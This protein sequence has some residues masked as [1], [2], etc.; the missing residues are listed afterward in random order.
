[1]MKKHLLMKTLLVA[2]VCL[3]GGTSSVWGASNFLTTWTGQVGTATN[4]G[5]FEY[6][7]KKVKIAAGETYVYTLTNFNDGNNEHYWQNWVVEGNLGDKYFDCEA[8]GH[9]WQAGSGPVPSYSQVMA[10]TDVEN[11]QTAYNGAN[12]TITIS[13]NAAGDQFTVT[14]TSN[15]LG[16]T[17]GNTDKYYGGTWTVAVGA[18]EEWD[19]YITEEYAHF[20][21]TKVVKN[22]SQFN[23]VS[24]ESAYTDQDNN[25]TN[26]DGTSVDNLKLYYTQYRDW[27]NNDGTVKVNTSGKMSFYKF[28]LTDIKNKLT[29]DGGTITGVTFSVYGN[30]DGGDCGKVRILGYNPVWSSSTITNA[31]VTN[32]AG[33]IPGT[34]SGTGSFQPLNTTSEMTMS[35]AGTTLTANALAYVNSAIAAG[36]DY[37]T[38]AMAANYTRTGL[39]KTWANLEFTYTAAVVYE[40]TFVETNSL[41]PTVTVYTDAERT[42]PIAKNELEANTTYYYRAVLAG[43]EN[44]EGT[45][46]VETSDPVVNFTMT[47]KTPVTSITVNY[48][49]NEAIVYS[50]VQSAIDGLYVGDSYNVPFRMYV[51]NG[52]TLYKSTKRGSNPWYGEPTILTANT[53]VEKAVTPVDLGG[54]AIV[55]FEDLDNSTAQNAGIRAS[56]CSAYDNRAY[57]SAENLP[58]GIYDFIVFGQNKTRGSSVKVGETTVFTAAEVGGAGSWNEHTFS[59]VAV[60]AAGKLSFVAGGSSTY[61]DY[62]IIIAVLK[63]VPVTVTDA[64]FATYVPSYDLNFSATEIEAYKVKVTSK[65]VA[66]LTKVNNVPAGTPVLLYKAGGDTENIP[67]MTGAAAVSDNDLVA[68]TG[69]AVATTV[70]EYTNMILNNVGGNVGFY[71]ANGQTVATNRAYLHFATTLAPDPAAARMTMIFEDD[72]VTGVNE[73]RSQKEDVRSEWFDLQGRKVAQPQKGLYIVNGKKVV[74]K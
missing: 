24:S 30:G 21:V 15:V 35:G 32:N 28:D 8:R 9:Q 55:L 10:Y 69:A 31:T 47:A 1:M 5:N 59:N 16:T 34:V 48:I 58:A 45:F 12:V 26:Y 70:G 4:S 56:Y 3:V 11:F 25:T 38:I 57:T 6:A 60:P 44:Y 36:Q 41:N 14:H 62:D 54:G 17:V 2:L 42:L 53:V 37:V 33:T 52:S 22:G 73:V 72:D 39:L 49:Y 18:E 74:L 19:I 20:V 51:M 64:A 13:R 61:D 40:A 65:G 23:Y 71:F 43:Y 50:E 27:G 63:S 66:T 7:T 68:G 67:V 46:D 29:T